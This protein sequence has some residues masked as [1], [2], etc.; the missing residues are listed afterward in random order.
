MHGPGTKPLRGK[1]GKKVEGRIQSR[2]ASQ[3]PTAGDDAT[4]PN[5]F[6]LEYAVRSTASELVRC[7]GGDRRR[8]M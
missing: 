6:L 2:S 7:A 5:L 4:G 8:G 3:T 1:V